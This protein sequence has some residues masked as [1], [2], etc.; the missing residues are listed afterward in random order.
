MKRLLQHPPGVNTTSGL[1]RCAFFFFFFYPFFFFSFIIFCSP[2]CSC[3]FFCWIYCYVLLTSRFSV[4][5]ESFRIRNFPKWEE[6]KQ[7]HFSF[8]SV[9]FFK[10]HILTV[11]SVCCQ[12]LSLFFFFSFLFFYF[13]L[14]FSFACFFFA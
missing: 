14:F 4:V 9:I 8:G 13:I 10:R 11:L 5:A 6:V 12:K 7:V 2:A 1:F 3:P